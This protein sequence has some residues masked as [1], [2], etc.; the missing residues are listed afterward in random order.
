MD[1]YIIRHARSVFG[2]KGADP[3]VSDAGKKEM[4]R[5]L[6]VAKGEFGFKPTL[7]ATSPILRAKQTAEIVKANDGG[8][9]KTVVEGSLSPDSKPEDVM[10]F[11]RTLKPGENVVLVTHMPVVFELLYHLIGGRGEVELLN[12]SIAAVR[13]DRRPAPG[14]G[15]LI[16]L[17]QTRG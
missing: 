10:A 1:V 5:M 2:P 14:K 6:G 9:V 16:W 15:K 12:G 7:I 13:F 17:L 3:P 4:V 8:S 11:L